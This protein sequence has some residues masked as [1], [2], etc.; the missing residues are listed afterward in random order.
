MDWEETKERARKVMAALE[1]MYPREYTENA[2]G[3]MDVNEW[4][5]AIECLCDN[6]S[7]APKPLTRE[8]F[9]ELRTVADSMGISARYLEILKVEEGT[10]KPV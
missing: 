7:E 1:A 2:R 10:S 4:K 9:D 6:I 8:V 3:F 5:I